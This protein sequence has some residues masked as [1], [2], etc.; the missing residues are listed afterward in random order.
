MKKSVFIIVIAVFI[1]VVVIAVGYAVNCHKEKT[2]AK[3]TE[4]NEEFMFYLHIDGEPDIS[5][6]N[7]DTQG[8][9]YSR[10]LGIIDV[11]FY[12]YY[13]GNNL[14]YDQLLEEYYAFCDGKDDY[15]RLKKY[16]DF[17]EESFHV[18][19]SEYGVGKM[20]ITKF[21]RFC[22][23]SI[24]SLYQLDN[25]W[26]IENANLTDEQILKVCDMALANESNMLRLILCD[27]FKDEYYA[28]YELLYNGFSD[29]ELDVNENDKQ[30][31]LE[32]NSVKYYLTYGD[33]GIY[34]E[35]DWYVTSIELYNTTNNY[36]IY[37]IQV[38][39][40]KSVVEVSVSNLDF[41]GFEKVCDKDELWTYYREGMC[42][43]IEFDEGICTKVSIEIIQ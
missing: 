34:G 20:D 7:I 8:L 3:M 22:L 35:N 28:G 24:A 13:S 9:T 29:E 6:K 31:E 14:T 5:Y 40:E 36:H 11:A 26:Q 12:N 2:I 15:D 19:Y 43:N 4:L 30:Y 41:Y 21:S 32:S 39:D 27:I 10:Y 23:K 1:I 18:L 25:V 16:I 37:G 17:C 38:G 42:I 33:Y